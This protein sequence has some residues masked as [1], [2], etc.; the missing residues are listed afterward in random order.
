MRQMYITDRR[1]CADLIGCMI[2]AADLGVEFIQIRE[3]DLSGRELLYLTD[4]AVRALTRWPVKILVN[5][6]VDVPL[7]V[8]AHGVHLPSDAPPPRIW[9]QIV[10][11]GFIIGRS[12]HTAA[13]V[14]AAQGAD[15]VVY[16]PV[17]DTPGKGPAKG[18]E[19][20]ANIAARSKVPVFALGG[21][22]SENAQ[23]CLDAGAAGVAA[24]RMFQE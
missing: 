15:F 10:P 21:V 16:G 12:C 7:A 2:R 14:E 3:K 23:S 4:S 24:I 13:E 18:L 22:T 17:F 6:R 20:L 8:G 5:S 1:G 11:S 19:P 9:R